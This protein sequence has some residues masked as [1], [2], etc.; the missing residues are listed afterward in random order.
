MVSKHVK[1]KRQGESGGIVKTEG[2]MYACKVMV[3]CPKCG[4][5][6]RVGVKVE[7]TGKDQKKVRYCK[8]CKQNL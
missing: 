4:K 1:P 2:A 6:T 7:G 8:K 5:A 3:V